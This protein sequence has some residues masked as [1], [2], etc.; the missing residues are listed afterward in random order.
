MWGGVHS[1]AY[2]GHLYLVCGVC[3][4]TIWRNI[5]VSK[6]TFSRNL[7]TQYAYTS[8]GTLIILCVIALL[9]I[10]HLSRLWYRRKINSTLRRSSSKLQKYQAARWN[11]GVK[12][13]RHCV[14]A[15]YN[16]KINLRWCFVEYEQ[17]SI[18]CAAGLSDAH[19]RA[20]ARG[21]WWV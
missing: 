16:C 2:G 11:R 20:Q 9:I 19:P 18:E 14:R 13:T 5:Y 10:Y 12:Y 1:V 6:P 8:T 17:W 3:D 7:L 15:I 21:W 4:V